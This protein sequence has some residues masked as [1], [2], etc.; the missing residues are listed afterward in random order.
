MD[1][2]AFYRT[3]LDRIVPGV[4]GELEIRSLSTYVRKLATT[5]NGTTIDR[6]GSVNSGGV[7]HWRGTFSL[8][9]TN[10]GLKFAVS[11]D[12]I[13]KSLIDSTYVQGV[14][15]ADNRAPPMMITNLSAEYEVRKGIRLFA[16]VT[17]LFNAPPPLIPQEPSA[18]S[19]LYNVSAFYNTQMIGQAWALGVRFNF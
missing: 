18:V 2:E 1:I 4:P 3:A 12:W 10:G 11:E 16:L 6:A 19:N 7:P 8:T 13:A 17:N 15:V 14:D 9:Y 5:F